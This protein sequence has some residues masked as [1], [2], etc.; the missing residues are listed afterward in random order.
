MEVDDF[1]EWLPYKVGFLKHETERQRARPRP[2]EIRAALREIAVACKRVRDAADDNRLRAHVNEL[3]R[4]LE[5]LDDISRSALQ[6]GLVDLERRPP[7]IL[8]PP[9]PGSSST[10]RPRHITLEDLLTSPSSSEVELAAATLAQALPHALARIPSKN[11]PGGTRPRTGDALARFA[12]DV[13]IE[14]EMLGV[15]VT[16]TRIE[17]AV[18]VR[19]GSTLS[20][21]LL[22]ALPAAGLPS[23]V[24]FAARQAAVREA[25]GDMSDEE[26]AN[27]MRAEGVDEDEIALYLATR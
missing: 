19:G 10:L 24:P 4:V 15:P 27:A 21:V 13:A 11:S 7:I 17:G 9:R 16:I 20:A 12:A 3:R 8:Q 26:L 6:G 1:L 23:S 22:A 18:G 25:R 14:L 2:R 5:R